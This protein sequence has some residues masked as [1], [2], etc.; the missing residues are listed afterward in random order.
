MKT[1]MFLCFHIN[2]KH[3]STKQ[4]FHVNVSFLEPTVIPHYII[5]VKGLLPTN[6]AF[7]RH[8]LP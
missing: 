7:M 8:E 4:C 1:S 5:M 2:S 3:E 6:D